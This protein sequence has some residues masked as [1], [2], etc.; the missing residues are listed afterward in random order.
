M[1]SAWQH[2]LDLLANERGTVVSFTIIRLFLAAILGGI[3]G[4]E[5]QLRKKPAGLRTNIFI[6]FGSAMFTILSDQL[7]RDYGGDHT[8][9]AAQIIPGIGFIGAGSIL[10]ARGSVTGLTTAA[11]L[12]VVASVGMAAGGGLY[13]TAIFATGVMLITLAALGRLERIFEL[14]TYRQSYEVVGRSVEE[15]LGTVNRILSEEH[16]SMQGVHAVSVG[17]QSRVVFEVDGPSEEHKT[18]SLR[19]RQANAFASVHPLGGT[20]RE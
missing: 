2:I 5:R 19:L 8:R 4:L 14:K 11:T 12:F 1:S 20:E 18:L 6:C 10:H 17:G 3:I 9:V 7:A 16:L 15:V 13:L